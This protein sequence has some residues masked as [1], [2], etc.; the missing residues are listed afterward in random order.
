[1]C[2]HGT[3]VGGGR[4]T[5]TDGLVDRECHLKGPEGPGWDEGG[6][7]GGGIRGHRV[8][9]GTDNGLEPKGGRAWGE[10][11]NDWLR[12]EASGRLR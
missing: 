3:S 6:K 9:G 1:M 7:G 5:K 2:P 11:Y 10:E 4:G 12:D 8:V